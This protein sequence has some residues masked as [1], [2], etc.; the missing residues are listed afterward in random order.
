MRALT[1][2][3]KR[4]AIHLL[5]VFLMKE[6]RYDPVVICS[7]NGKRNGRLPRFPPKWRHAGGPRIT[8]ALEC[9]EKCS[10]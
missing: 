6:V 10:G 1:S 5:C 2:S 8:V 9:C 4:R 3:R 7:N